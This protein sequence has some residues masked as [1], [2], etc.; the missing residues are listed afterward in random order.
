MIKIHADNKI[1][2]KE[3]TAKIDTNKE[4][5]FKKKVETLEVDEYIPIDPE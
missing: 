2:K 1:E 4:L 5:C 3:I